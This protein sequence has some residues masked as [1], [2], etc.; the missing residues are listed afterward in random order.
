M[1]LLCKLCLNCVS[2]TTNSF[3]DL[4]YFLLAKIILYLI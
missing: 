4:F 1:H 2:T 3:S